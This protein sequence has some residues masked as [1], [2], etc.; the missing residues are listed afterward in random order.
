MVGG[1]AS[2]GRIFHSFKV[3]RKMDKKVNYVSRGGFGRS[4]SQ[5]AARMELLIS[6]KTGRL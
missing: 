5:K 6:P 3:S 4:R 2:A 1:R